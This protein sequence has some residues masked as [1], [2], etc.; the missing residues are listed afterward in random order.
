M[1]LFAGTFEN[2]VDGKFRVSLPAPFRAE[3]GDKKGASDKTGDKK[4]VPAVSVYLYPSDQLPL[5]EGCTVE[6]MDETRASINRTRPRRDLKRIALQMRTFGRAR[7]VKIE[8]GGRLVL[9]R[10]FAE[11]F[12]I[13]ECA[14]FVGL[15][16]IFFIG[17]P[18]TVAQAFEDA[19]RRAEEEDLA[20]EMFEPTG[21]GGQ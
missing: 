13:G 14:V 11:Q 19:D 16:D 5:L 17:N 4:E 6:W 20:V 21:G 1:A 18:E 10:E 15:G 8:D 7:Q 2:K 9:P 12:G 3:L